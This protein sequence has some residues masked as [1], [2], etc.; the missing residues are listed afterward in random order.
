MSVRFGVK[1]RDALALLQ[2]CSIPVPTAANHIARWQ[3]SGSLGSGRCLRLGHSE[4]LL[5]QDDGSAL[6]E[7]VREAF[8]HF[9]GSAWLLPRADHC[10][11]ITAPHAPGWAAACHWTTALARVCSFDFE[12]LRRDPDLVAMTLLADI[13][14]TLTADAPATDAPA[15]PGG[16]FTLRLWCDPSYATY[17][18]DCLQTLFQHTSELTGDQR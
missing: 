9:T 11:Q 5:E 17:L 4:F 6:L 2:S 7:Q 8:R 1:G 15:A 13:S 3:H 14:V 12:Q 10:V 16:A 18:N